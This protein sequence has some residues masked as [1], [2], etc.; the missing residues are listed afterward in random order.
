MAPCLVCPHGPNRESG[1]G[2]VFV[3]GLSEHIVRSPSDMLDLLKLGST[4]R[5]TGGRVCLCACVCLSVSVCLCLSVCVCVPVSVCV[6]V[7]VS[8]TLCLS[9]S[10]YSLPSAAHT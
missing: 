3:Q 9:V 1:D 4:M 6:S 10:V 8:V 5:T 2:G 7:S